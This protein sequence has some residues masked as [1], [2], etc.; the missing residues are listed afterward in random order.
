M[1]ISLR[2]RLIQMDYEQKLVR[3]TA[4]AD[5]ESLPTPAGVVSLKTGD[6]IDLPRWQARLLESKG[7]VSI[8]DK[9]V[10]I[11]IIN[12]YHFKEKRKTAANQITALPQDFYP[13]AFEL[14]RKLDELIKE[15]P[16]HMFLKDREIVE[17]NLTELAEA[18]L[19]KIIRLA[20]TNEGGLRDRLTPEE[21]IVFDS[22]HSVI[23][24]W[25]DYIKS[26]F[27]RE[28]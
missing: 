21:T 23:S 14:V 25:R 11:N 6:E 1:D 16:A 19:A 13:K 28:E 17:K 7:L 2:L 4:L 3:V 5:I 8:K 12:M 27:R 9:E 10:D 26:P 24:S 18:R 20:T 22:L 15:N